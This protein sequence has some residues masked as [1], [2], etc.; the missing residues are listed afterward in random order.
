MIED[1]LKVVELQEG[2]DKV[3]KQEVSIQ[4]VDE[5]QVIFE[6][7]ELIKVDHLV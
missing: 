2:Y 7:Q 1:Q 6:L 4:L 3:Q 5:V